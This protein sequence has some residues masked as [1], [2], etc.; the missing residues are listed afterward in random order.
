MPRK[1]VFHSQLPG[2]P[3][4]LLQGDRDPMLTMQPDYLDC[5][6]D[7][8]PAGDLGKNMSAGSSAACSQYSSL[9]WY[10]TALLCYILYNSS[11]WFF[12]I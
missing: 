7:P 5:R 6:L 1:V 8:D 12:N 2:D 11:L 4:I 10:Y 9:S 3:Q